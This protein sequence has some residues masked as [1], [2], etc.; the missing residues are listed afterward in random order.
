[1]HYGVEVMTKEDLRIEF[2]LIHAQKYKQAIN[3]NE[4]YTSVIT[5]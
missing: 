1:M 5:M 4:Y 3:E 2:Y